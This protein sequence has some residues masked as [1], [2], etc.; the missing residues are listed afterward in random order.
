VCVVYCLDSQFV[1]DV[2]KFVAGS[3]QVLSAMAQL[4]VPHVSVLTKVDLLA[5]PVR[6]PWCATVTEL[7]RARSVPFGMQNG[8]LGSHAWDQSSSDGPSWLRRCLDVC[9]VNPLDGGCCPALAVCGTRVIQER[10]M[11]P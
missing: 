1:T 6:G 5:N 11:K 2:A 4:E 7:C 8:T 3:L 9:R 10:L